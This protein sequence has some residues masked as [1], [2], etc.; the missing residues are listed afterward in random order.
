[1]KELLSELEGR[2]ISD[3][4]LPLNSSQ[5]TQI[6]HIFI[7]KKGIFIIEEKHYSGD[8]YGAL[9]D[10]NWTAVYGY[11]K[12]KHRMMN[13]FIQNKTH[14]AG[15][16]RSIKRDDKNIISVVLLTG[17]SRFMAEPVPNWLCRNCDDLANKFTSYVTEPVLSVEEVGW[18]ES[19]LRKSM[20]PQTLLTDLG[21]VYSLKLKHR[22]PISVPHRVTYFTLLTTTLFFRA[23]KKLFSRKRSEVIHKQYRE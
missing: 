12:A 13:P 2:L 22:Q 6:D 21:H 16:C 23:L 17:R 5:T 11:G 1:L 3:V 14:I 10:K 20:L 7:C 18:I 15:V 19:D 8:L 4:T 9:D